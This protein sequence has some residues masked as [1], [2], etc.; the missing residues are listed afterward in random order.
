MVMAMEWAMMIKTIMNLMM[1]KWRSK[2]IRTFSFKAEKIIVTSL[3]EIILR[4]GTSVDKV[5]RK[6]ETNY[7]ALRRK[8]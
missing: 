1:K 5:K 7:Q 8:T 6:K 3:L 2:A 4:K